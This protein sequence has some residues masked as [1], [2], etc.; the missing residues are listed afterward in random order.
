MKQH[1]QYGN[2]LLFDLLEREENIVHFTTTR[3]GGVSRG[4]FASFNMGNFSDDN[5][6][7]ISE[8]RE[9]LARMLYMDISRFIIPHQTHGTEV[10]TIDKD[11]LSLDHATAI[12]TLYGVDAVITREKEIY[13]CITTADCVPIILYDKGNNVIAAIHAGWR[14]TVGRIV[15]KTVIAMEKQFGSLPEDMIA[16]IG[17]AIGMSNYEVGNEVVDRFYEEGFDLTDVASFS[18]KTP[19]SKYHVDLKEINRKELIRLGIDAGCIEKSP[20]CTFDREDIFF[21]ARRQT[22]HSGRMLTGIMM[23]R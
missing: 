16:G 5:P 22:V 1:P 21:S 4:D 6:L 7:N 2:L 3:E 13:L 23:K 17:P 19:S 9:I 20:L 8:N 15:E 18:R 14:G 11:F 10:L 12:E